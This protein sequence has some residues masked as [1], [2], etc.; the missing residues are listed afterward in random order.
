[1]KIY[2]KTGDT[3]TTSLVGGSRVAKIDVRLEAYGTIDEL[4]SFLGLLRAEVEQEGIR[5]FLLKIQQNMFVV[6]GYLA[7]DTTK[8][9]LPPSLKLDETEIVV[10]ETA[11]DEIAEKLP[12]LKDFVIPGTNRSSALCHVCRSVAR[13]AERRIYALEGEAE[14]CSEVK[15]YINRLSDYLFVLARFLEF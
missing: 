9:A 6:G 10:L 7:T 14:I 12:P 8:I 2:T 11:I 13:R 5:E 3:G 4:N 15:K 1:M